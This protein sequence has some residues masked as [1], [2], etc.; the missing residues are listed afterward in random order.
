MHMP[1][2]DLKGQTSANQ[3]QYAPKCNRFLLG[4]CH[5]QQSKFHKK[6]ACNLSMNLPING[7]TMHQTELKIELVQRPE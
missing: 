3:G 5:N 1:L 2:I 7:P 6:R 4:P